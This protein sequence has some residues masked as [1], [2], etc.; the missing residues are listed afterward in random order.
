[1]A[2]L[3]IVFGLL[4]GILG[5]VFYYVTDRVSVT[6]LIPTFFGIIFIVLGFLAL[7]VKW[8]RHAMHGAALFG[9]IGLIVPAFMAVREY[10]KG[11]EMNGKKVAELGLMAALCG[12]FLV[13]CIKSFIDARRRRRQQG[14]S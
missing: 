9:L 14:N 7:S 13:L 6:A 2:P 12:V 4:L 11:E 3:A 1:V 10:G 5:A 8:R